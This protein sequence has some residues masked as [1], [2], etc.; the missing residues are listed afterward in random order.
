MGKKS[1]SAQVIGFAYF[2]GMAVAVA[3]K[4]DE[5]I[6]FKFKGD[7]VKEPHLKSSGSFEAKTGQQMGGGN[8]SGNKDSKIYFYD[9]TQTQADPYIAKQTGSSMC[10][11]N[12]SYFVIN[13]FI[14]D[15]VSSC[16]EYSIIA[17]RTKLGVSF[18][19][20]DTLSDINGDINPA[21]ALWYILTSKIKLSEEF[22]DSSSFLNVAKALKNEGFGV[23]FVMSRSNEA[24]EW[25]KEILRTIDGVLYINKSNSKLSLK[26][27]RDDYNPDTLFKINESNS[28]N[29]KFTRKSWDD[30][31]SKCII[32]YTDNTQ[33]IES[34]VSAINTATKNTIGYEKTYECEFMAISNA[35]NA[36][37]VLNRTMRKMSY[38]F[39]SVKMQVS[40]ELFK[41]LSVGDVVIFSND[42][43][44]VKDMKLRILNLGGEKDEPYIDVEAVEDVF[45]LKNL[46]VTSVQDSL[47]KPVDLKVGAIEYI[48]LVEATIEN[49][50]EQGVI[51]MA[52][53]PTGMVQYFTASDGLSGDTI[54]LDKTWALAELNEPLEVTGEVAR[55]AKFIVR[56]ITPLWAVN[57]TDAGWQRLKMTCLIDDEYINF[58]T[59]KSLGDGL[60][61]VSYLIR[62]LSG[63]EIKKHL[64]GAK[65]WFAPKDANDLDVLELISPKTTIYFKAGNFADSAETKKL[66][67]N[68]SG[69]A[70]MPYPI[71]NL[72]AW[73]KDSKTY[74]K[75][76]NCV[77]LHGANFRSSDVISAGV[78]ENLM[79]NEVLLKISDGSEFHIKADNFEYE[80]NKHL[81]YS[82][83]NVAYTTGILSKEVKI[84][85]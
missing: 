44:K 84:T 68:H 2:L 72:K 11:K 19:I 39:A 42:K 47:Y 5:L 73:K 32:K 49:G 58:K 28:T 59:R 23:S 36:K 56:E 1:K 81:T 14:G 34:S 65:V 9:G 4:V 53:T 54:N 45:A 85:I 8:G 78:D 29:V 82:F 79:E 18:D 50:S 64:K 37:I 80:T 10:Y 24:K 43:L 52:I 35:R 51:P 48:N 70:K 69:K 63:K 75:W 16:P 62:G 17:K 7:V 40:A 22:L 3:T 60:W 67:F 15:N 57:A 27:L 76:V 77:R 66:E 13:G 26:I 31:Y 30:T 38:P 41:D 71:S 21:H 33:N 83:Y 20:N 61:E 55:E 74:F 46:T 6:K 25:I 12:T